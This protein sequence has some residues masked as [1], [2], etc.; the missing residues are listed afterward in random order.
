MPL[1]DVPPFDPG[2]RP[3]RRLC[4]SEHIAAFL[5]DEENERAGFL[6]DDLDGFVKG[7]KITI[8]MKPRDAG[9]AFMGILDPAADCKFD[10]RSRD[11][12]PGLRIIGAFREKD[13]FVG[14]VLRVRRIMK[15]P[16]WVQAI[17]ECEQLWRLHFHNS[18][19]T[20]SNPSVF[21]TNWHNV[22]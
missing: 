3:V 6:L 18:P 10:I 7:N 21:L 9:I 13:F 12:S 14:L 19:L 16:D 11:P 2:I 5:E 8:S 22:D 20:G 4:V 17:D 15:E 1:Y